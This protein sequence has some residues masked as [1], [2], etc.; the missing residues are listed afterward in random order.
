MTLSEIIAASIVRDVCELEPSDDGH[1]TLRVRVGDLRAIVASRLEAPTPEQYYDE[2]FKHSMGGCAENYVNNA[3]YKALRDAVIKQM[4]AAPPAQSVDSD[5]ARVCAAVVER[6]ATQ[7]RIAELEARD[8][9]A[10]VWTWLMDYCKRRGVPPA[11]QNE[12]FKLCDDLRKA[13]TGAGR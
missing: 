7:A 12:L 4:I 2:G 3:D 1:D 6:D 5:A 8:P 10:F 9:A 11:A 13:L